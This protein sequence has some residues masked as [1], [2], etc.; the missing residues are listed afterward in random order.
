MTT[1]TRPA[2]TTIDFNGN[3]IEDTALCTFAGSDECLIFLDG[4]TDAAEP[5]FA[6]SAFGVGAT[7]FTGMGQCDLNDDGVRE[8]TIGTGDRCLVFAAGGGD[9]VTIMDVD[10]GGS[11]SACADID[12]DG[13]DDLIVSLDFE[14]LIGI[15]GDLILGA[16][17]GGVIDGP[18]SGG[19]ELLTPSN[20]TIR[21]THGPAA[22][23][24]VNDTSLR[25]YELDGGDMDLTTCA[26]GCTGE[27]LPGDGLVWESFGI[28]TDHLVAIN[29][30]G[31]V[32]LTDIALNLFRMVGGVPSEIGQVAVLQDGTLMV[33]LIAPPETKKIHLEPDGDVVGYGVLSG[34][35]DDQ[36]QRPTPLVGA[37]SVL[38]G[39]VAPSEFSVHDVEGLS[40]PGDPF[41]GGDEIGDLVLDDA[42]LD[43][44][45]PTPVNV[46]NI[47][48][49]DFVPQP[50]I[51]SESPLL[52][53]T[54]QVD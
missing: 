16:R 37:G 48:I 23:L 2:A 14:R 15:E 22:G 54:F 39:P 27:L 6:V 11:R 1:T 51:V 52:D 34:P 17:P 25:R 53:D 30:D 8:V 18:G 36:L 31:G 12:G 44:G 4:V 42:S 38:V 45:P 47:G 41:F 32:V 5:D 10:C 7:D 26:G 9:P 19:P 21:A 29:E 40:H 24:F 28:A 35:I 20:A 33:G 49:I 3:G 43:L 46:P 13:D 50:F